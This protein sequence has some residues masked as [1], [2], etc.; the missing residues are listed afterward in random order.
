MRPDKV[1]VHFFEG[2]YRNLR[3]IIL[4]WEKYNFYKFLIRFYIENTS[5]NHDLKENVKEIM[6]GFLDKRIIVLYYE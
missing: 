4:I 1:I 6:Q 3:L 2:F 5:G